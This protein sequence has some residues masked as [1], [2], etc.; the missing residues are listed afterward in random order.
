M[1]IKTQ[2]VD[3][4]TRIITKVVDDEIRVSC[5]CCACCAAINEGLLLSL[6]GRRGDKALQTFDSQNYTD[7]T[8][9]FN[10]IAYI[11]QAG[12]FNGGKPS[13]PQR[14]NWHRTKACMRFLC[15]C[16]T[17]KDSEIT[18]QINVPYGS[19]WTG[20]DMWTD[21]LQPEFGDETSSGTYVY[22]L[23][24]FGWRYRPPDILNGYP[25]SG[26]SVFVGD[27]SFYTLAKYEVTLNE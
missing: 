25:P 6:L 15:R 17:V 4:E 26:E 16:V 12:T 1:T 13:T 11:E 24:F 3:D 21:I 14:L 8:L 9:T 10:N 18:S 2:V 27:D 7:G 23:I 20:K 22:A 5:T 19:T